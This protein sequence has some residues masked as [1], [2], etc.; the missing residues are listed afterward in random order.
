MSKIG[1]DLHFEFDP[2]DGLILRTANDANSAICAFHWKPAFFERCT[3][4]PLRKR[5]Q[6]DQVFKCRVPVRAMAAVTKSRKGVASLRIRNESSSEQ[7]NLSFEFRLEKNDAFIN[8]IHRLGVVDADG[9]NPVTDR[10]GASEI[11]ALPRF[12]LRMMEPL[13]KVT[14]VALIVNDK[15]KIVTMKSYHREAHQQ[16]GNIVLQT[17]LATLLKSETSA[18]AHEFEEFL[19]Q[20]EHGA[21]CTKIDAPANVKDEVTLVFSLGE[22]KAMLQF[23]AAVTDEDL[24]VKLLFDWGGRPLVLETKAPT[25]SGELVMATLDHKL[26]GIFQ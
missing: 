20:D 10:R 11:V 17:K 12:L 2:L 9:I 25:F 8:V 18:C 16:Q 6:D 26:L 13:R 3:A 19:F 1:K 14:Q 7:L 22:P 4:P 5:S 23:C 15:A 21:A 24:R